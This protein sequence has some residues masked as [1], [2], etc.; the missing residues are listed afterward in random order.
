MDFF[1]RIARL[2]DAALNDDTV[3]PGSA[4]GAVSGD[5]DYHEAW[6]E[7]DDYLK[8]AEAHYRGEERPAPEAGLPPEILQAYRD[9]EVSPY[10]S[11]GE[12]REAYR[13]L[14][15]RYHPDRFGASPEKQKLA[16]EIATR[17]NESY[18]RIRNYLGD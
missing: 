9:L 15:I 7:L 5:R 8:G 1:N 14:Q 6:K 17:L 13:R 3:S 12:V 4:S 16:T 10:A 11:L 18:A 2:I